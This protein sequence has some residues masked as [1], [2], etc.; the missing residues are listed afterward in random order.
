MEFSRELYHL[1]VRNV[2][3]RSDLFTLCTVSKHFQ[4]EAERALYNTLHLRG[5]ARTMDVCRILS[6]AHRVSALVDALSVFIADDRSED[7]A[8]SEHTSIPPGF[9]DVIASALQQVRKLRFLSMHFEHVRDTAQAWVLSGCTFQLHTFHCEFEWDGDLAAFLYSQKDLTDLYL[10]DYRSN[11][12]F[13]PDRKDSSR[14]S[15]LALA[16]PKL[17]MLECTFSEAAMALVPGR[18]V[19]RV[20]TCFSSSENDEKRAEMNQLLTKLRLSRKALRALDL[21]D[22][23]YTEDFS[24]EILT[25]MGGGAFPHFSELRYLGTLVLPVDG[26]KACL[27]CLCYVTSLISLFLR[28]LENHL[29][30]APHALPQTAMR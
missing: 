26:R 28:F 19:V 13:D 20:K 24:L 4:Q 17:A 30:W 27:G 7:D 25:H 1:I 11:A 29:L 15:S 6:S 14:P 9:W 12:M 2:T 10:V 3:S 22:E 18:P 21:A 23:S 16:L 8:E 5:Y